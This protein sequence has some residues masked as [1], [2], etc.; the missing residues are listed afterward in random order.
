MRGI[1]HFSRWSRRCVRW[2]Y[3]LLRFRRRHAD[4]SWRCSRLPLGMPSP[5]LPALFW[6][7]LHMPSTVAA[8]HGGDVLPPR[9]FGVFFLGPPLP[10]CRHRRT[11]RCARSFGRFVLLS[12]LGCCCCHFIL[13][14]F[15]YIPKLS[16]GSKSMVIVPP[17][18]RMGDSQK[19]QTFLPPS[20][21]V[22]SH[23]IFFVA[24]AHLPITTTYFNMKC[25]TDDE[26]NHRPHVIVTS[27]VAWNPQTLDIPRGCKRKWANEEHEA[28]WGQATWNK[29]CGM[30]RD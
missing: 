29:S 6:G 26:I 22:E 23:T 2:A 14:L 1:V 24:G 30:K 13:K 18:T 19:S 16:H 11:R 17:Q 25:P 9:P 12:C 5:K 27:P 4:W 20:D 3:V 8:C 10:R 15:N 7:A 28:F 21:S